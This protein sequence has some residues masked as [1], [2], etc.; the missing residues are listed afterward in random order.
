MTAAAKQKIAL[1]EKGRTEF[2]RRMRARLKKST[3]SQRVDALVSAGIITKQ[4]KLAVAYR[5]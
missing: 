3:Q 2:R 4:G 1:I 5:D